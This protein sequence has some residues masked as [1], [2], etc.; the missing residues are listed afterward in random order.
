[1]ARRGGL[2]GTH[3]VV[4]LA[5]CVVVFTLSAC[6]SS[7]TALATQRSGSSTASHPSGSSLLV[8]LEPMNSGASAQGLAA[9]AR[10]FERRARDLG[11]ANDVSVS[12]RN[13][14][15]ILDLRGS[16]AQADLGELGQMDQLFF[17]PVLCAAPAYSPPVSSSTTTTT[18]PAKKHKPAAYVVPPACGTNYKYSISNYSAANGAYN[19][20][21]GPDPALASAPSTPVLQDTPSR[22][23]LVSAKSNSTGVARYELGPTAYDGT[24]PATSDI[25]ASASAQYNATS[26]EGWVVNFTIKSQYSAFFDTIAKANYHLPLAIDVGAYVESAPTINATSFGGSGQIAGSFTHRQASSLAL[27]LASGAVPLPLRVA[28]TQTSG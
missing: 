27:L 14:T 7:G 1:L 28:Y 3:L 13:S 25:L 2:P 12:T 15:I 17:R 5:F 18:V 21:P 9:D 10:I 26:G 4:S 8:T 19:P 24:V 22:I 16:R 20:G 23:V 11:I 6:G